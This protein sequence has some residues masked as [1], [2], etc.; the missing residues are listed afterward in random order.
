MERNR[1]GRYLK[2]RAEAMRES[3]RAVVQ[4]LRKKEG[5]QRA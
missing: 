1:V 5:M 4:E 2:G 3:A